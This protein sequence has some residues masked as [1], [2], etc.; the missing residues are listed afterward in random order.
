MAMNVHRIMGE[1]HPQARLLVD[2]DQVV[3]RIVDAIGH[4]RDVVNIE[5][6]N[7]ASNGSGGAVADALAGA[8]ERGVEVNVIVDQAALIGTPPLGALRQIRRLRSIG[9]NVVLNNYLADHPG[10]SYTDHRKVVTVDGEIAFIG[11]INLGKITDSYHDAMFELRGAAAHQ[12]SH[13]QALRWQEVGKVVSARHGAALHDAARGARL[14]SSP[15][16]LIR[17]A[18]HIKQFDMTEY[19]LDRIRGAR[20]RIWIASPGYSDLRIVDALADAARR[21]VDVRIISPGKP[22]LRLPII[23]WNA[24]A[25]LRRVMDAG[26]TVYEYPGVSH[27][28]A[29]ITDNEC[30]LGTYNATRRS[31]E[32]DQEIGVTSSHPQVVGQVEHLLSEDIARSRRLTGEDMER[33]VQRATNFLLDRIKLEY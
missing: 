4:A 18:P 12:L 30:A 26:G 17:N 5:M 25:N 3:P 23:I 11:G 6:F 7:F 32:H 2:I 21:G 33:P 20:D 13:E 15:V 1:A 16:R 8:V 22:P 10:A 24:R 27:L 14:V 29:L 31:A 19:Y 28:K 9:A